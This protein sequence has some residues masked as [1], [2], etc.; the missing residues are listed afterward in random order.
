MNAA[1][2]LLDDP[3]LATLLAALARTGAET[4]IVGGAVRD[5]LFGLPPHEIDL[6]TTALPEA[7][8][9]AAREA[10]LK[11]V[12][13]GIEHGTVTIVVAGAPF[14]VT[15]L[16]E[17]VETDGR[18][19]VVRFGGDFEQDAKRR[20]FTVNALSLTPDGKLHDYTGGL[21]DIAAKR[22]RFIGDAATRIRED[23]LR[24]LRFF[25]F[26]A[27]HGEGDFDR[28]G[29]HE[30]IMARENLSRLSRERIRAEII[31]LLPARRAPE[32]MRAMSHAGIIEVLLG[33]GYPARLERLAAFE[34][35]RGRQGDAALRLAAFSALTMED[36]DR[37]R[38]R[39]RLSN[40]EHA[41][42]VAAAKTLAALHGIER[43]PP[44]SHL[45][46][47]LFLCGS[48]AACDALALAFAESRAAPDDQRW[49]EAA[50][51]LEETPAPAFPIKGADLV[52]LG[53]A[54]GRALGAALKSLQAKWIRAGFPRD[55]AVVQQLVE[56]AI[57]GNE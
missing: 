26:N 10:G 49:R 35:A 30:S 40:D 50:A 33:M 2:Q 27:S 45:R 38:L 54:P 23:Y 25:R 55:P 1:Q 32:I 3:R 28:E 16:R 37:L 13:T 22:I 31:K 53:V 39:L 14:E 46:E 17:D 42:L 34:A 44:V 57:R 36:A 48:R 7:V 11:G 19:A 51:Y 29:L 9:A 41:R 56:D 21:K 5:A 43:P 8:L 20:D 4:R 12:P 47:M 24:V 6:A 15:T 18:Y 52:A